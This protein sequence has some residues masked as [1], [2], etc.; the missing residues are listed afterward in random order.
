LKPTLPNPPIYHKDGERNL[1]KAMADIERAIAEGRHSRTCMHVCH[2]CR[3]WVDAIYY[4]TDKGAELCA[5]CS[6]AAGKLG[7]D[8]ALRL[9]VIEHSEFQRIKAAQARTQAILNQAKGMMAP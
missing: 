7:E 2:G 9:G 8:I 1:P 3:E 6:H 5:R 4:R